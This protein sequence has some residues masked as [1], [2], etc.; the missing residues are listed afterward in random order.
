MS[1]EENRILFSSVLVKLLKGVIYS[2][3]NDKLWDELIKRQSAVRDYFKVLGLDVIIYEDEGFAWLKQ[4]TAQEGVDEIPRLMPRRQLSFSVSLL[5]ALLRKKLVE[6][7]SSSGE[8]RL[9]IGRDDLLEDT[10]TFYPQ[11]TNE[12]RFK[13]RFDTS[14]NKIESM[15]FVRPIGDGGSSLEV[16]RIIKGFVDA[17]WLAE[18]DTRLQE[19]VKYAGAKEVNE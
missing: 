2:V 5:L 3:D 1:T 19:Y 17:S 14:V 8:R 12:V 11:G 16:C 9:I 4:T 13:Q 15:G 10:K 7:D 18:F 6:H